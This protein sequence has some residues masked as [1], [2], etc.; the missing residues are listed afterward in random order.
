MKVLVTGGR[1]CA[2]VSHVHRVLDTIHSVDPIEVIIEGGALGA[3]TLAYNWAKEN[4]VDSYRVRAKW[5]DQ[6]KAAG[7]IRNGRML[8]VLGLPDMVVAFPGGRG[9]ASMVDIVEQLNKIAGKELIEILDEREMK[10]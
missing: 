9:T 2:M 6:G 3:D 7:H 4:H 10:F 8:E 1:K 5:D